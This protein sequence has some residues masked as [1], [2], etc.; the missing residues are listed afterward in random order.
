[1]IKHSRFSAITL[2]QSLA[3]K[4][5]AQELKEMSLES[6]KKQGID[7]FLVTIKYPNDI[8][9]YQ[10][11]SKKIETLNKPELELFWIK[12][13]HKIFENEYD[14]KMFSPMELFFLETE[15]IYL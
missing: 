7:L 2:E 13:L 1:M 3:L 12:I 6:L 8:N 15:G 14:K 5:F 9:D 10:L 4:K 11:F